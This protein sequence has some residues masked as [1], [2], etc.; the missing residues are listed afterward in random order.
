[1]CIRG[2][3]AVKYP[4]VIPHGNIISSR[5]GEMADAISDEIWP[6]S[7]PK[8]AKMSHKKAQIH[9]SAAAAFLE[10]R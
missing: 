7:N 2:P 10:V 3:L 8:R 1:M 5:R 6:L 9:T 4:A